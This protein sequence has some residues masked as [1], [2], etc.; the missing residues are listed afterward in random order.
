MT[1]FFASRLL[2]LIAIIAFVPFARAA[3]TKLSAEQ[4]AAHALN[5]LGFG[6]RP[7][8]A[9]RVAKMG[10]EKW[11]EA[12][13]HPEN[14]DDGEIA[15]RLKP[16]VTLNYSPY[17]LMLA[18]DIDKANFVKRAVQKQQ[19]ELRKQGATP[20]EIQAV[21]K[22]GNA[23][24]PELLA[25]LNAKERQTI[26]EAQ[27][28]NIQPNDSV[29]AV[30]ELQQERFIRAVHS[31][32][33]LQEVLVDFWSNHF[34]LDVKK[35]PVRALKIVDEHEVI[36][37]YVFAHFRDLL[38]A[39][40]KS[41]AMMAY[42]DNARSTV[43]MKLT[44]RE[45]GR[46]RQR[47][48]Q[49]L[50]RK[51]N[52]ENDEAKEEIAM[53][54]MPET[55]GG[56]NEN[57]GRELMEL[58][59]LGVDGG[60]T[61][62][63]VREVARCFTGWGLNQKTGEFQFRSQAHDNGE[64]TVLGHKIPAGGGTRDGETVLDILA[65]NP[66]TARHIATKLCMRFIA[67]TPPQSIVD[68]AAQTFA[69]TNG[70]LREV[71]KTIVLSPEFFSTAA[72]RAKIKSP[73]EYAVSAVRALDGEVDPTA[74]D[75]KIGGR[76]AKGRG[77]KRGNIGGDG[78]VARVRL[79]ALADGASSVRPDANNRGFKTLALEIATMGQ[80]LFSY[81]APTGYPED[82][83]QW[84]STGALVARLNYALAL[85][86]GQVQGVEIPQSETSDL[87]TLLQQ[88]LNSEVSAGTRATLQ[89][90]IKADNKPDAAKIAALIIGSPEF[91]RK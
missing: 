48:Q 89:D 82:S 55:R 29:R 52:A 35:G 37:P 27:K 51:G 28:N 18:Y 19:D 43:E 1:K 71:V 69:R 86:G 6:A 81:Q 9:Q 56:L 61:Q 26:D 3:E 76:L 78:E 21:R 31:N 2:L 57:Y 58:H 59:T 5:R 33:Q 88:L 54:E 70:D 47:M 15:A 85:T 67:D 68:K 25:L 63:D 84:V 42:L 41:P 79:L 17:Q 49:R 7:G 72:Y 83:S 36:R 38:G 62:N 10:V 40:A 12:Q 75:L 77:G 32:R 50:A 87:D 4:K 46:M 65:S 45:Q 74:A 73:F 13:L 16:L 53:P 64:K 20:A 11:I 60:Y 22:K 44:P 91:Q 80:P 90:Q 39:S 30:G 8:E 14:I 66:A 23:L 24:T 34:N